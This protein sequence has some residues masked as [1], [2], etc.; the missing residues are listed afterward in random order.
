MQHGFYGSILPHW[1]LDGEAVHVLSL[2]HGKQFTSDFSSGKAAL[3]IF[4]HFYEDT[5]DILQK[6]SKNIFSSIQAWRGVHKCK[7]IC[8]SLATFNAHRPRKSVTTLVLVVIN[9][10]FCLFS[11]C[12]F[13]KGPWNECQ[14]HSAT[15]CLCCCE[16]YWCMRQL[17]RKEQDICK[18][19]ANS[20]TFG[21]CSDSTKIHVLVCLEI[22]TT[23]AKVGC[24][25]FTLF[26][27]PVFYIK[28]TLKFS[29]TNRDVFCL[30]LRMK[31]AEIVGD[32]HL[33]ITTYKALAQSFQTV[34]CSLLHI[35][36]AAFIGIPGSITFHVVLPLFIFQLNCDFEDGICVLFILLP[37]EL[38]MDFSPEVLKHLRSE[39]LSLA[40]LWLLICFI[41]ICLSFK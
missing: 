31:K 3:Y 38:S 6:P 5:H 29:G 4:G 24:V 32:I 20:F 7:M 40:G 34:R 21:F 22:L 1:P 13:R 9:R 35:L 36:R 10:A 28:N 41:F 12:P 2:A 18:N 39:W 37:P 15:L 14:H 11:I 30:E 17:K 26:L 27:M 8:P 19:L 16:S 23:K 33:I 25:H